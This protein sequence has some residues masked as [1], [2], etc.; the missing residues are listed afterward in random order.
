MAN[1][2]L[3]ILFIVLFVLVGALNLAR[4]L[5]RTDS[6]RPLSLGLGAAGLLWAA[7]AGL[8]RFVD[9]AAG[10]VAALLAAAVMLGASLASLRRPSG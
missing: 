7:S 9:H 4:G 2:N 3:W 8:F 10:Y 1:P 5:R 6:R